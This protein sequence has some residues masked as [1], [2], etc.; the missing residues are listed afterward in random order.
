MG[1][2]HASNM[3]TPAFHPTKQALLLL[4]V[5]AHAASTA[6]KHWGRPKFVGKS[7]L[8]TGGDSGIG[9]AAVEAFYYEC[10]RVMI[11]GHNPA[12]TQAAWQNLS[13]TVPAPDC[14]EDMPGMLSWTV[15]DISNQSQVEQMMQTTIEK[16]G[17]LDIAVNNAGSGGSSPGNAYQIAD[18]G[19]VE[20]FD[21]SLEMKVNVHGTLKCMHAQIKFWLEHKQPGVIVNVASICGEFAGCAPAYLS[22][23]WATIGFSKQAAL[24]YAGADIRVNVLA[25]GAVNTLMLR[26]GLSRDDPRWIAREKVLTAEIPNHRIAEPWEMAGPITFLASDMSSY[27]T[28]HVLTVDGDVTLGTSSL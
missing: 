6:P 14:P 25:P 20:Y 21:S 19:F 9:L 13:S 23:K 7:V 3:R 28:G 17:G 10:A 18:D 8:V 11:V 2:H 4:C 1:A 24:K 5:I 27:M 15:A 22:S 26:D 16:L 12:K